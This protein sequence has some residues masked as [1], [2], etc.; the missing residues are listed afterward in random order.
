MCSIKLQQGSDQLCLGTG[1]QIYFFFLL[2]DVEKK[3]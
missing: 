3:M 1:D 2:L